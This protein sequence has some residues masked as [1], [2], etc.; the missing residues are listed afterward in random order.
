MGMQNQPVYNKVGNE[1]KESK[2]EEHEF[3]FSLDSVSSMVCMQ[4]TSLRSTGYQA[5]AAALRW[6]GRQKLLH[7]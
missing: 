3:N 7:L 5:Q 2:Y 1:K 6:E 4:L